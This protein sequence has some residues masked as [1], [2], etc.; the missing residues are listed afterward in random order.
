MSGGGDWSESLFKP[1]KGDALGDGS[2]GQ[3]SDEP[4]LAPVAWDKLPEA[5]NKQKLRARLAT[6]APGSQK[7]SGLLDIKTLAP[8]LMKGDSGGARSPASAEA[9]GD[10]TGVDAA[11]DAIE[12]STSKND[13]K[14]SSSLVDQPI[15]STPKGDSGPAPVVQQAQQGRGP[16]MMMMVVLMLAVAGLAAYVFI[17]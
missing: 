2:W 7:E 12:S 16:M 8:D 10:K 6:P 15:V 9:S 17:K 14:M 4:E 13:G 11:L 1:E 5:P 3:S